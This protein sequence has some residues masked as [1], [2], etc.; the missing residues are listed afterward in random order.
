M[1]SCGLEQGGHPGGAFNENPRIRDS[2]SLGKRRSLMV[3]Q[4]P[5]RSPDKK[6]EGKLE[7]DSSPAS[8]ERIKTERRC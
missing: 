7:S 3:V 1:M 6:E 4:P 8:L 2:V 5:D